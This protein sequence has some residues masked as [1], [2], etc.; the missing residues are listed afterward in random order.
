MAEG[1]VIKWRSH[2][3]A[4]RGNEQVTL[5]L[6]GREGNIW[7]SV[8]SREI[9]HRGPST[10]E[11]V[12]L[13]HEFKASFLSRSHQ[14]RKGAIRWDQHDVKKAILT[15]NLRVQLEWE[16]GDGKLSRQQLFRK[17][18]RGEKRYQPA[19]KE[20]V[21]KPFQQQTPFFQVNSCLAS[22]L[23]LLLLHLWSRYK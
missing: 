22:T 3:S 23:P 8:L 11:A 2:T 18:L 19:F 13:C 17:N 20:E 21:V 4:E 1:W 10:I 12:K 5:D 15:V 16:R 14:C 6:A 9:E 7:V